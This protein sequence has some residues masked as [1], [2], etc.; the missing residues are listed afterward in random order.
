MTQERRIERDILGGAVAG[1]PGA[2][3]GGVLGAA[4]GALMGDAADAAGEPPARR[5]D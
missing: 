1:L 4:A 3:V 2:A 5:G